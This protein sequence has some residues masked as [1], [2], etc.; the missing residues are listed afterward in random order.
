MLRVTLFALVTSLGLVAVPGPAPSRAPAAGPGLVQR[1]FAT[2]PP[3][4]RHQGDPA[5]SLYKLAREHLNQGDYRQAAALF[6]SL[7]DRYPNSSYA[8]DALYWHAFALYRQGG[9]EE[10]RR[11]QVALQEQKKRFP[12][13]N[14]RG[15]A[16]ALAARINGALA[17]TGDAD[18]AEAVTAEARAAAFEAE[19]AGAVA[20]QVAVQAERTG[21]EM[22]AAKAGMEAAKAALEA[23]RP[24]MEVVGAMG[25]G[26][27][28][29]QAL[30]P[31]C[32]GQ[33]EKAAM[34]VA[35]LNALLQMD[36]DQALPVL[37]DVLKRRDACSAPLR[38]QAVFLI[39]QKRT[40]ETE[41]ILLDLVR[42]DPDPG[43][44]EQ[45]VFWLSQVPGPKALKAIQEVL[46]SA[47]DRSLQEKALFALSQ[48]RSPEAAAAL[49]RFADNAA[50]PADLREKAIFWI[51]QDATA[52]NAEF[53]RQLFKRADNPR[54]KE[55]ILFSLS[56]MHGSG[57]S[58]FLVD[59]ATDASQP[60]NVR[61][62]ALFWAS[63][64]GGLSVAELSKLYD[65]SA[66][67][68]M[69]EQI[70]F[71]MSQRKDAVDKLLEVARTEKDP[72][73]RS[74]AIFWLGQSRDPRAAKVLQEIINQ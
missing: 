59:V 28:R 71:A 62:Q 43:V 61:K 3:A 20:D 13:A 41:D 24:A 32:A 35:A 23:A 16:E 2:V 34:R 40:D 18:A 33:E 10:L 51:G 69:R 63:Q 56:Q 4:P 50:A 15:D 11:A 1:P 58:R 7:V 22:E 37:R 25:P 46:A 74:K 45:A 65:A 57:D 21:A 54:T 5:D 6:R 66:D 14:T 19:R 48:H 38:R 68:S 67:K 52:D 30:P 47:T 12:N 49:R 31:E 70:L 53:L 42:N 44:R 36:A 17:R 39:S 64:E 29:R 60:L 73:L 9:S 26:G 55:R 8:P 27:S 72:S